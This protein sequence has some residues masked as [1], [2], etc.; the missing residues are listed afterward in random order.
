MNQELTEC[1]DDL[2]QKIPLTVE[3]LFSGFLEE[4]QPTLLIL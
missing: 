1:I 4:D 3:I 2:L